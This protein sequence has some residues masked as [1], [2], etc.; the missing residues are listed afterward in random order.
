MCRMPIHSSEFLK[1]E[2]DETSISAAELAPQLRLL[3]NQ[4]SEMTHGRLSIPADTALR[5][6][7]R[8]G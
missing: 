5:G 1:D 3:E 2:L 4:I 7:D 8:V 6:Y